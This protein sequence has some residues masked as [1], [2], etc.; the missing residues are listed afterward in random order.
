MY[1]WRQIFSDDF[2]SYA[3]QAAYEAAYP[4][5]VLGNVT[6]ANP[7]NWS[8]T[9]G[10]DGQPGVS[11]SIVE[12]AAWGNMG[13][14]APE[15]RAFRFEI[16]LDHVT[17]VG[18]TIG[19][20]LSFVSA[21]SASSFIQL[22]SG[23]S[24]PQN[25]DDVILTAGTGSTVGY[26]VADALPNTTVGKF[27]QIYMLASTSTGTSWNAD[28]AIELFVDGVSLAYEE[29]I[30]ANGRP[31]LDYAGGD[32]YFD[33]FLFTA[34][35]KVTDLAIYD[36]GEGGSPGGGGS[37]APSTGS[38]RNLLTGRQHTVEGSDNLLAGISNAIEGDDSQ[39]HGEDAT[40]N[41]THSVLFNLCDHPVTLSTDRTFQ[42]CA[43]S[44]ILNGVEYESPGS[45]GQFA[46][47]GATYITVDDETAGL[48]NSRQLIAGTGIVID[49]SVAGEIEISSTGG[50][51]SP[52]S[53]GP[54]TASPIVVTFVIDGGGSVITTG[55]KS[56]SPP[57][58]VTGTITRWTLFSA[59][60]ATTSGSIVIDIWSDVYGSYP[61]VNAD[62]ITASAP[63][64]LSSATK[65]QDSTLTG[66]TT[67]VTAGAIWRF[68]VD[69]VSAVSHIVLGIE[70]EP[71]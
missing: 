20:L 12:H 28:G 40:V 27:L 59:D 66:W 15:G 13:A 67:A 64:T 2:S 32:P 25:D 65:N 70:I 33:G 26:I 4:A 52:G 16:L 49:T 57:I 69:S 63:P 19:Y 41:A 37:P 39:A 56:V 50:P 6:A 11:S 17:P 35:G 8:L 42:V 62:S 55:I 47:A 44:I 9:N 61:P 5:T 51:G 21:G 14:L 38:A 24:S 60:A 34:H 58:P 54:S 36:T 18:G 10:P 31:T 29:G 46:D 30:L 7:A 48:P 22:Q 43:D 23:I 3:N 68:N 45:P 71:T 53:P 1:D